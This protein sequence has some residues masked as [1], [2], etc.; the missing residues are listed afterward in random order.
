MSTGAEAVATALQAAG[1]KLAFGLPG[2]HNL[3]LWP[4]CATAGIRIVGTRHEQGSVYAADGYARVTRQVGIVFATTGP[5]ATNTLTGVGEAWAAKSPL[6][7]IVTNIS[8]QVRQENVY[9]GALHECSDQSGIFAPLTKHLF[10]V[11]NPDK[12]SSTI[13]HAITI[14]ETAP[15]G[16]VYLEIPTNFLLE[17]TTLPEKTWQS[18]RLRKTAETKKPNS[19]RSTAASTTSSYDLTKNVSKNLSDDVSNSISNNV[20]NDFPSDLSNKIDDCLAL[21]EASERPLIWIGGGARECGSAV[22]TL[23]EKLHAPVLATHQARCVL[24]ASHELLVTIPPHEPIV[25]DLVTHADLAI[26]IGSDLD[27]MMTQNWALPLPRI[28]AAI[29]IDEADARK[30]YEMDLVLCGDANL[31]TQTLAT[32]VTAK[33]PT[34]WPPDLRALADRAKEALARHTDTASAMRFIENTERAIPEDCLLLTDMAIC[35]YWILGY[36]RPPLQG[37]MFSSLPWGTLG[38]AL[39]AAIGAALGT[40]HKHPVVVFCGDGGFLFCLAELAVLKEEHLPVTVVV[41]DNGGYGMLRAT[42]NGNTT[43][44]ELRQPDIARLSRA[45]ELRTRE[46]TGVEAQYS[47]ALAEAVRSGE[48]NVLHVISDLHPPRTTSPYWPLR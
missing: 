23:A 8:T 41:F 31:L 5:G 39:P 28:R 4:A 33:N 12:I 21:M 13:S 24:P 48:P 45:F 40:K 20:C 43:A 27:Q 46:A 32:R 34:S 1:V 11:T 29:N 22:A 19:P 30:N 35:G 16:P 25:T 3:A 42:P 38:W 15:Q 17:K 47:V 9:R 14:A 36:H 6:L 18:S 26:V 2:A 44:T 37:A 10:I 7:V